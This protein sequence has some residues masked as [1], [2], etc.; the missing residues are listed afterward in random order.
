[1]LKKKKL[2]FFLLIFLLNFTSLLAQEKQE[3]LGLIK[4]NDSSFISYR[5]ILFEDKGTISGYSITDLSGDHET[6]SNIIGTYIEKTNT[7]NFKEVGIIYTKSEVS[8]YD[9]CYI[10]FNGKIGNLNSRSNII[11]K[12][13]G[14][15]ND[16]S[17]CINGELK[18]QNIE[19]IE[20]K[21]E[22]VDKIIQKSKKL[23][24]NIKSEVNLS[25]TLDSLKMNILK[26]NQNLSMFTSSN[27]LKLKIYDA[28]KVDGDKINLIINDTII[29]KDYTVSKEIK[30]ITIPLTLEKTTIKILAQNVGTIS[31]NTARIEIL[32][33]KNNISTLT[34]LHKGE[35]TSITIHKLK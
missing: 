15:Y 34:N 8:D 25:K 9:F 35:Q 33:Q 31:P 27:Q 6:K 13:N 17:T 11:G 4:L 12:F 7:I 19:K 1:M 16:G 2:I 18:L 23:S 22:R 32:D 5:L 28:G 21:A 26:S 3:Y 10:H 14:Q 20:R 30:E 24:N 29:L